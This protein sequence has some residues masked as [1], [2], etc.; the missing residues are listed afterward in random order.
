[1]KRLILA[2]GAF[3][4]LISLTA[5]PG[6]GGKKGNEFV[7]SPNSC[8]NYTYNHQTGGYVDPRTGQPVQ[9]TPYYFGAGSNG[10]FMPWNQFQGGQF[11]NGC[12]TWSNVYPG[13]FYVP[14]NV[15]G[16]GMMCV[17]VTYFNSVPGWNSWYTMNGAF[18]SYA[19]NCQVGV[20]CPAN[21]FGAS[22]GANAGPL[23][24]GGTLALCL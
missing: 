20:N 15:M 13:S 21:C 16:A 9:C 24:L 2:F 17:K 8:F 18:P 7:T 19:M 4:A 23:W 5:C 22:A 10:Q 1:M 6:G 3:A 12:E 14:M 11:V